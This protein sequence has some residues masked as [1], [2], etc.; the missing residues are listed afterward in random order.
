MSAEERGADRNLPLA[1]EAARGRK[2]PDLGLGVE[3]IAGL[4]LDGGRALADQRVQPR[5]RAG[6]EFGFARVAR[7]GH[8]RDDTAA[9]ARDFFIARALQAQL[10]FVRAVAAIDE[11][12]VAIDQAGR[13]PAAFAIDPLDRVRIRRKIRLRAGI[14]N[15]AI[16]RRDHAMLDLA[17]IG[18]VG[19][20][21]GEPGVMPDPVETLCH[22]M[23]P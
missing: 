4:D 2:L 9:R 19:A 22:A 14:D 16:A 10:E 21:R 20:H 8:G 18:T 13:D 6:D 17:E 1:A 11:M 12:G 3:A 23:V 7:G 15:A 5:Q